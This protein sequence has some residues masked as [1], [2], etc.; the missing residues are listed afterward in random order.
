MMVKCLSSLTWITLG[1]TALKEESKD[2]TTSV[3]LTTCIQLFRQRLS[4]KS[5]KAYATMLIGIMGRKIL[6][7][8]D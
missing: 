8:I 5:I 1:Y 3:S 2:K 4:Y 6:E 7:L